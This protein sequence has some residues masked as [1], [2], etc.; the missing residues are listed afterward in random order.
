MSEASAPIAP[1][2]DEAAR[3]AG[4]AEH[5]ETIVEILAAKVL[6]DWL[7][8]RQQLLVPFSIDLAKREPGEVS[9][10]IEAM[11]SAA[12]AD[13]TVDGKERERVEGALS[14]LNAGEEQRAMVEKVIAHP[15]ALAAI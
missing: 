14:L 4:P 10:L 11:L 13:G 8:N 3:E 9:L 12:Q 6:I 5:D 2:A 15:R 7:R 1:D